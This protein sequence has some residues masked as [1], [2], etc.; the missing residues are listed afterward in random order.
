MFLLF[1]TGQCIYI[2]T[3]S[4]VRL[5]GICMILCELTAIPVPLFQSTL[6]HGENKVLLW[7]SNLLS[8]Y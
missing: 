4:H 5:N 1:V 7:K 3:E 8:L 6:H 2:T